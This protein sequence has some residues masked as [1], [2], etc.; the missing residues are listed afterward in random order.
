MGNYA[1][2][3]PLW[4]EAY[5]DDPDNA[6]VEYYFADTLARAEAYEELEQFVLSASFSIENKLYFLLRGQ[7]NDRA[8][9]IANEA[10]GS[11]AAVPLV[12]SNGRNIVIV[13]RAIALKRLNREEEMLAGLAELEESGS[14]DEPHTMAGVA[15]LRGDRDLML[16]SLRQAVGTKLSRDDLIV[17][18]VFEEYRDDPEFIAIVEAAA[19]DDAMFSAGQL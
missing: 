5:K 12:E 10:L 1:E 16:E 8:L 9:E 18:P 11:Q 6:G 19:G 15:A 14:V 2:A 7:R 3:I 4:R 13:N 17:F